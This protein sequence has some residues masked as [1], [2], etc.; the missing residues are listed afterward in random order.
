MTIDKHFA[1]EVTAIQ[2]EITMTFLD[3]DLAEGVCVLSL[4]LFTVLIASFIL[5]EETSSAYVGESGAS[6]SSLLCSMI[7]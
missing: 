4:S 5:L 2:G 6:A 3:F 7:W 1:R